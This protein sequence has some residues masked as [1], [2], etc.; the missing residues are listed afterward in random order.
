[1]R[2]VH[3]GWTYDG[4][5]IEAYDIIYPDDLAV[6]VAAAVPRVRQGAD[7]HPGRIGFATAVDGSDRQ[8]RRQPRRH[9]SDLHGRRPADLRE[10]AGQ[11]D[12]TAL[13]RGEGEDLRLG[14]LGRPE[15]HARSA[16][17]ATAVGA[18]ARSVRP[19]RQAG[20]QQDQGPDGRQD[21]VLRLRLCGA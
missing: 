16:G 15:D 19:R 6:P 9:P 2:L 13:V 11:G 18:A 12:E 5:A 8:D 10:G 7:R 1:M 17:G 14:V 20:V 21:Q 4:V 3:D